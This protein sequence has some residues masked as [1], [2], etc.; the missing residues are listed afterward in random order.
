LH[1]GRTRKPENKINKE[2]EKP[3]IRDSTLAESGVG[4]NIREGQ[5]VGLPNELPIFYMKP[6]IE[7]LNGPNNGKPNNDKESNLNE[8]LMFLKMF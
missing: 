6:K 7:V 3:F 4:E 5:C 8:E 2:L 1:A